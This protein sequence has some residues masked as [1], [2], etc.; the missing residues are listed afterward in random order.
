MEYISKDAQTLLYLLKEKLIKEKRVEFY[1]INGLR[2]I[3]FGNMLGEGTSGIPPIKILSGSKLEEAKERVKN[4]LNE[5]VCHDLVV[6]QGRENSNE[7]YRIKHSAIIEVDKIN[8]TAK[9]E[10][11]LLY[12]PQPHS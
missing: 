10:F 12:G 5:L 1:Y 2:L 6:L 3:V 11:E 9:D 4:A 7:I 8:F